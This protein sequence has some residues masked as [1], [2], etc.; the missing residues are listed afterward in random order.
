[1]NSLCQR[2]IFPVLS[3]F[4]SP[5]SERQS[6]VKATI[7]NGGAFVEDGEYVP[8]RGWV[9]S[10]RFPAAKMEVYTG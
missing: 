6:S 9:F 4:P 8:S 10:G 7:G 2:T 5:G 3:W 1:M